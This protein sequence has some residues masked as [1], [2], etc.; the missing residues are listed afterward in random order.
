MYSARNSRRWTS[1]FRQATRGLASG[2]Q[3]GRDLK[4][5]NGER[6]L[7]SRPVNAL[8]M[9]TVNLRGILILSSFANLGGVAPSL[10]SFDPHSSTSIFN[11]TLNGVPQF[12]Q[13]RLFK[14][15]LTSHPDPTSPARMWK[16]EELRTKSEA[17]LY[18]LRHRA[19]PT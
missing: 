7:G 2:A 14:P 5:R 8:V 9:L 4:H 16:W 10:K 6:P 15:D 3:S 17:R 19:F 18:R 1:H 12:R 11:H 13:N